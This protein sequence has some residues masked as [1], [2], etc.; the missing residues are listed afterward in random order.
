M[1]LENVDDRVAHLARR[2]QLAGMVAGGE[3]PAGAA[4]VLV[5]TP[6]QP[7][8]QTAQAG[9]ERALGAGLDDEVKVVGLDGEVD[10]AERGGAAGVA[11]GDLAEHAADGA[12]EVAAA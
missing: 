7:D 12:R 2:A 1:V 11:L 10:D 3:D 8:A 6:R 5:E 4:E 9:G